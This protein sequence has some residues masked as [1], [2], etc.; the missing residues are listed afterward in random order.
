M[1]LLELDHV[2]KRYRRG[3]RERLA[4]GD[5]SLAVE[6]GE[7]VSVWGMRGSGRSTL[8][9]V[10][11]GIELPDSGVVRFD[12]RTL[13]D[14]RRRLPSR[15]IG[16]C[17]RALRPAEGRVVLEHATTGLLARGVRESVARERARE[18][19]RRTGVEECE[20]LEPAELSGG[21]AV[22]VA[23]ARALAPG[24]RLLIVDEPTAGV[25]VEERDRLLAL[26]RSL[27]NEGIAV[28]ASAGELSAGLAGADRALALRA[29]ELHGE[30][31]A[32]LATVVEL[33]GPSV[34]RATG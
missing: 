5:V 8:L 11:A 19:L 32:E 34:W 31:R 23:I 3:S 10:A 22:R 25:E 26:L 30:S 28:L 7:L 18:A 4:L 27:A 1:A 13:F 16:F 21:E 2:S 24:P 12:G 17:L 20:M 15:E 29:G 6:A 33:H 14:G 9:R